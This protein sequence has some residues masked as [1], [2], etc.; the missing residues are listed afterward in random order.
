MKCKMCKKET[1][2]NERICKKCLKELNSKA[3]KEEVDEFKKIV[4]AENLEVTKD[5]TNLKDLMNNNIDDDFKDIKDSKLITA[6][7]ILFGFIVI[8]LITFIVIWLI[9]KPKEII[10]EKKPSTDYEA[11]LK[12]YGDIVS[13]KAKDY[14]DENKEIPTWQSLAELIEYNKYEIVCQTHNIYIDGS[15][16][17]KQCKVNN[18]S[19]KYTYGEEK[20]D[21]K[22]GKEI[23]IYKKDDNYSTEQLEGSELLGTFTCNTLDCEY[24][25][26]FDKYVIVKE[27]QSNYLYNYVSNALEFGPFNNETLLVYNDTL[28]GIYYKDG[29]K[30]N[31]YNISLGKNIKNING[32]IDFEKDYVDTGIQY[33]YGY[34]ITYSNGFN[35]VNMKTG[36]IS[37]TIKENIKN[38]TEDIKSGIL[39]IIIGDKTSNKFKIYN[40]NGK[41]MFNG[42]EFIDFK[43]TS[44]TLVTF[45]ENNFKVY[46]NKLN[47]KVTSKNYNNILKGFDDFIIVI[48][49]KKIKL[50][51]YNDKEIVTFSTEWNT[52]YRIFDTSFRYNIVD[53]VLSIIFIDTEDDSYF[54]YYYDFNTKE[55]KEETV[56]TME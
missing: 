50:V 54:N 42:D 6:F 21:A 3:S 27:K 36:N 14:I 17:L 34:L 48:D 13:E 41:L 9:R 45:T 46:D 1:T 39:Y 20:K 40:N 24:V 37:F 7:Y 53:K 33:K 28:Y 32:D 12:E 47:V 15:V 8:G 43:I 44:N 22:T 19:I 56:E 55:T 30:N 11:I 16:F 25:K 35:F 38:F 29:G 31:L 23:S 10:E 5:L 2:N 52:D 51:D 4:E 18:K 26:A 49:N